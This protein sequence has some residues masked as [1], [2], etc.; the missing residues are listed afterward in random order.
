M[1]LKGEA[2]VRVQSKGKIFFLIC[3]DGVASGGTEFP[4]FATAFFK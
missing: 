3:E 4:G 2:L 1:A